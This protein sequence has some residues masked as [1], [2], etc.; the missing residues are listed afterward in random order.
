[1]GVSAAI[2]LT[3]A[4]SIKLCSRL[5]RAQP[6]SNDLDGSTRPEERPHPD[7]T[8]AVGG[9]GTPVRNLPSTK[10]SWI[11]VRGS[12]GMLGEDRSAGKRL[13][14][15]DVPGDVNAQIRGDRLLQTLICRG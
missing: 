15:S 5:T 4:R 3:M 6:S 13:E 2:R 8:I 14:E 9:G 7:H 1:M 11:R 10:S 12:H